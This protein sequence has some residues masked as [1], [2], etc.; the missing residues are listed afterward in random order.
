[1]SYRPL[2]LGHFW[3]RGAS[4]ASMKPDTFVHPLTLLQSH[5]YSTPL[6]LPPLHPHQP[7]HPHPPPLPTIQLRPN[8]QVKSQ[9]ATPSPIKI[10][11]ILHPPPLTPLHDPIMPIKRTLISP[12]PQPSSPQ[13]HLPTI[14]TE[15]PQLRSV[16]CPVVLWGES[17]F[18]VLDLS[19][20]ALVDG[21]VD[22]HD[23]CHVRGVGGVVFPAHGFKEHL[24]RRVDPIRRRGILAW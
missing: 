24:L 23:G 2:F 7:P 10:N 20:G 15:T 13:A 19:P 8:I 18:P 17:L 6:L 9:P 11:H 1:M 5:I 14:P 4:Q 16:A 22:R 3:R 21:I 12:Q